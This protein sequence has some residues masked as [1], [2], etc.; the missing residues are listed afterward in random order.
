[1]AYKK[2]THTHTHMRRQLT[3]IVEKEKLEVKSI[4]VGKKMITY[5]PV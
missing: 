5:H 2:H 4:E 3:E 1:M